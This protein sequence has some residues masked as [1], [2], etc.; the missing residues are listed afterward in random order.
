MASEPPSRNCVICIDVRL[1]LM[2]MGTRIRSAV[3]V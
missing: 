3:M 1:R 2:N